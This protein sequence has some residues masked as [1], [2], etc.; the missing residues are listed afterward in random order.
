MPPYPLSH[1]AHLGGEANI[2]TDMIT[3]VMRMIEIMRTMMMFKAK[4]G[5]QNIPNAII[6]LK[7]LDLLSAGGS[8]SIYQL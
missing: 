8:V 2:H 7:D 1:L 6:N 3:I 5:P 4:V